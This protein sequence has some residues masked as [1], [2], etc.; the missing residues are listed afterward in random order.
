MKSIYI[1]FI[2]IYVVAVHP[3]VGFSSLIHLRAIVKCPSALPTTFRDLWTPTLLLCVKCPWGD[4][5][6][7]VIVALPPEM[8]AL[9]I[10]AL[11]RWPGLTLPTGSVAEW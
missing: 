1:K 5:L 10:E 11:Q 7:N 9:H 4:P 3:L 2:D 6:S 8:K